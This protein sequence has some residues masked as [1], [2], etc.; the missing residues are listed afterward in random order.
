[1]IFGEYVYSIRYLTNI[2]FGEYRVGTGNYLELAA[3]FC[4]F[5]REPY[6]YP[7]VWY[8]QQWCH[9]QVYS[10]NDHYYNILKDFV[11]RE[12]VQILRIFLSRMYVDSYENDPARLYGSAQVSK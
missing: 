11:L 7:A 4:C 3:I 10:S 1:M 5:R 8:W 2:V 12:C 6:C 9:C